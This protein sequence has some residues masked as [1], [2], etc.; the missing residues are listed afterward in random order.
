MALADAMNAMAQAVADATAEMRELANAVSSTGDVQA[1]TDQLNALA[2][3]L[4]Q[5]VND[6]H[7]AHPDVVP[8]VDQ[9]SGGTPSGETP[10][11]QPPLDSPPV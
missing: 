7:A 10:P 3:N 6:A 1:A 4:E 5:A 11:D 2:A 9:S 8:P